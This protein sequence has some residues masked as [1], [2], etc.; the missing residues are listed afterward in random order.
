MTIDEF[1]DVIHKLNPADF[2]KFVFDLLKR[3]DRFKDVRMQ[4]GTMN[5][6][7][8][9]EATEVEPLPGKPRRWVFLVKKIL[10]FGVDV[11]N[12]MYPIAQ[13]ALKRGPTQVVIVV[14]GNI[15]SS[16]LE[17][18]EKSGIEVWG[19]QVLVGYATPELRAAWLSEKALGVLSLDNITSQKAE[20]FVFKLQATV[21]GKGEWPT[22][23]RLVADVIEFL[24][25]PPLQPPRYELPDADGR[26]RRDVLFENSASSGFW[27]QIRYD[28]S[29]HNIV[30]DAKNHVNQIKKN[31]VIDI[32]HYLKSYGCGMFAFLVSRYPPSNAAVHATRE[33]WI[34]D[35]KMIVHID[36]ICLIEMLN[37]RGNDGEPE[38][39]IRRRIAEFRMSL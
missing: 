14:S 20:A 12:Y 39:V 31:T 10:L 25:C 27:A 7:I 15:T 26:N 32:A 23:Q 36:D 37:I 33:Q 17:Y 19:S 11:A 5:Q 3:S 2:K 6:G 34:S 24:F 4:S 22:Y 1:Q 13:I 21:P 28:Y 18:L 16:A 35:N 8:D 30:V 29:A 9:I 38:D